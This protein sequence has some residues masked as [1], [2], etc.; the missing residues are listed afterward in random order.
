MNINENA[1]NAI[2][3]TPVYTSI[4]DIQVATHEDANQQKL[5]SYIIMHCHAK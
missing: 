1:I 4:E 2:V 3:N 5:K